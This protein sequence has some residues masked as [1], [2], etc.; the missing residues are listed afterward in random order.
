MSCV[1]VNFFLHLPVNAHV[2]DAKVLEGE[3]V[4]PC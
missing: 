4:G 3:N 1:N 2:V